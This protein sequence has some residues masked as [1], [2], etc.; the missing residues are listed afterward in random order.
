MKNVTPAKVVAN[1]VGIGAFAVVAGWM[2]F[3]YL[4][5]EKASICAERYA[6]ATR[7]SLTD[8]DGVLLSTS[9]LQARLG[10]SEWGVMENSQVLASDIAAAEAILAVNVGQGTGSGFMPKAPRGGISF[11]WKPYEMAD[12]RAACLSYDVRLPSD[13][14]FGASG[15]LPG[16][17]AGSDFD[18]RGTPSDVTG[19]GLRLV[20]GEAGVAGLYLQTAG[21]PTWKH[22]PIARSKTSLSRGKWVSI[23]QEL[24]LDAESR[25]I[26]RFWIDGELAAESKKFK[27]PGDEATR[28]EGVLADVHFGTVTNQATS[29]KDFRLEITP[30]VIRWQ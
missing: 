30:F 16:L 2:V 6:S 19:A 18:P 1:V 3:S 22:V 4:T 9:S 28:V 15:S 29:P 5:V 25:A 13:F 23:E 7:L 17:Y 10:A 20:W 11:L 26:A 12:A 21:D 8:S 14:Q 24:I 27:L